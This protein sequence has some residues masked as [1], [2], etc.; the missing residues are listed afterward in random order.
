MNLR[1]LI[2]A[3]LVVFSIK[4]IAQDKK[5]YRIL[6][7]IKGIGNAKVLLGNKPKNGYGPGFEI[8]YFDS[9]YSKDDQFFF[10]GHADELTFYSIEV[11]GIANGWVS[12]I[13]ENTTIEIK[14]VKDSLYRSKITGSTQNEVYE[15]YRKDVSYPL[16]VRR[17]AL[18]RVID[19]LKKRSDATQVKTFEKT[20]LAQYNR[21]NETNIGRFIEQAPA[22]YGAL[23]ELS[24]IADFIKADTAKKY[25][26]KLSDELA[27]TAL[28]KKLRYMLFDYPELVSLKK[29]V[30]FFSMPDTSGRIRNITEFRGKYVLV[31]FWASWCIP[32]L[33]E[34]PE[35]KRLDSTYKSEGFQILGISMDTNRKLWTE[36]IAKHKIDWSNLSDLKGND[37]KAAILLNVSAIPVKFLLD[38]EGNILL[39][40]ASLSEIEKV[41]ST[42]ISH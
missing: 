34:L 2:L 31:D 41:L 42:A 19:S 13:A 7:K 18:Y 14:G 25:Y 39:K 3:L 23:Y 33:K 40:D 1:N 17:R 15:A 24:G 27:N 5:E 28:G 6:G 8:R 12:F 32:C 10:N 36:A 30:P 11:P 16:S 38:P 29:P 21:E 37:N 20:Y 35:L 26:L 9:C 22:N 4:G